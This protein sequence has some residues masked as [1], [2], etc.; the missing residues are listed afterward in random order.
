M[1]A[2]TLR[3]TP[4]GWSRLLELLKVLPVHVGAPRI[5]G[6]HTEVDEERLAEILD[7]WLSKIETQQDYNF[8][9]DVVAML[10]F[11]RAELEAD[12]EAR[13]VDLVET[14]SCLGPAGAAALGH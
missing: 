4:N 11:Q 2:S 1:Q 13:I 10:V 9:V 8:A 7:E 14:A 12:I 3:L 5:F 6:W